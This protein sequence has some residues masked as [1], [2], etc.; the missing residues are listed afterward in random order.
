MVDRVGRCDEPAARPQDARELGECP[1]E[2]GDVIEHPRRDGD[3]ELL[4]LERQ[5]LD[6]AE[7]RV[8]P[9]SALDLDHSLR[10]VDADQLRAELTDD[11]LGHLAL[12]AA[13]LEDA[14]RPRL[15]D[16]LEEDLARVGPFGSLIRGLPRREIGLALVLVSDEGVVVEARHEGTNPWRPSA[17]SPPRPRSPRGSSPASAGSA[18]TRASARSPPAARSATGSSP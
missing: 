11:S 16:S 9:L 18:A 12:P 2:V 1:I 4:V 14:A 13:D 8:D 3:V 6:V 17:R 5:V 15:G 7:P 10:L